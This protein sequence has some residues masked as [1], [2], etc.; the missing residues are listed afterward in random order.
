MRDKNYKLELRPLAALEVIEA[1]DWYEL[2][3]QGLGIEF[4]NELEIFYQKLL[5]NPHIHSYYQKPVRSGKI[6]RFPYVVV[7][8]IFN[9]VIIVYSVFMA[10]QNPA[11]KRTK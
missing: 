8:E 5:Q 11:N 1:Y 3:R 6:E 4:L 10:K 9:E 2:Q 7:Y